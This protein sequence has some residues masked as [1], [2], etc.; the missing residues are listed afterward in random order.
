M[1]AMLILLDCSL[2]VW[3][4]EITGWGLHYS[5]KNLS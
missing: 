2:P 4:V 1:L 3:H 5:N